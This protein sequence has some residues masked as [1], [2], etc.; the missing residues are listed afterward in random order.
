[1]TPIYT[2]TK[3]IDDIEMYF[4][5]YAS[6]ELAK[7]FEKDFVSGEFV[8]NNDKVVV[9]LHGNGECTQ[10]FSDNV[11]S[12]CA[13]SY[14]ILI[15]SRGHG[16]TTAGDSEF[17]I[18]LMAEDLS[19]LCDELN[20]GKYKLLGFSDGGNIAITY[21][22]RHPERLSHL[23]VAG[24]NLNPQGMKF[25]TKLAI[26]IKYFFAK[27]SKDKSEKHRIK[28]EL[29][30]LM[31]NYPHI[32]SRLLGNVECSS[33]VLEGKRD[34]IKH[35]HTQL[36]AKSMKNSKLVT[37]PN[38]GHNIFKD[39]TDFVNKIISDFFTDKF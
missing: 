38:S 33:L 10:I 23:V 1:M 35:K 13:E 37:V 7:T 8:S 26:S 32:S 24:A 18:D 14:V 29:L 15:D 11:S 31:I 20:I 39:N 2:S 36:I 22:V 19:K 17:T 34:V 21:A 28:T 3:K 30:S 25:F 6:G 4:E 12:L 16:K 27:L 5:I 9:M